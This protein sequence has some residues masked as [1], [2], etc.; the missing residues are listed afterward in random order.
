MALVKTF[1][2]ATGVT[3]V[4]ESESYWDAEKKQSRSRRKLVGK[5]DENGNVV[6]TGKLGRPK[7]APPTEAQV[8]NV[9][10]LY[11]DKEELIA[12]LKEAELEI[13]RLRK[14]ICDLEDEKSG[15][16]AKVEKLLAEIKE[17]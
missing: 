9:E 2:K 13:Y 7:L 8:R 3:Y 1:N 12:K 11:K 4:Y 6:A 16:I 15:I 10:N 17:Q 5:L 14:Q